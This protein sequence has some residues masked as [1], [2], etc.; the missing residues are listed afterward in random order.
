MSGYVRVCQHIFWALTE[1][2]TVTVLLVAR[3][4]EGLTAL[5]YIRVC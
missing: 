1:G 4:T 2:A 5:R 3:G